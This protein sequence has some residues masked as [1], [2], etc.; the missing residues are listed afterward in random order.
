MFTAQEIELGKEPT[1]PFLGLDERWHRPFLA[2]E[3]VRWAGEI[4][5]VVLAP[6]PGR[7]VDA[8]ELVEVDYEPLPVV[9]DAREALENEVLLFEDAGTNVCLERPATTSDEELFGDCEVTASGTITS[10][11]IAACPIEPRAAAARVEDDDR[12]TVWLSTQTPH[13]DRDGLAAILGTDPGLI[14]VLAPDVGGGFGGKGLE[15]GVRAGRLPG[16]EDGKP[17]R[18]TETR[19]ENLLRCRT[20]AR[21]GSSSR[22]GAAATGPSRRCG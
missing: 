8:A 4:V 18:W 11:R 19:T 1:L 13:Q 15:R 10:Q 6:S 17:V 7:S 2:G 20:G 12:L 21:S 5:A 22:S 3:K 9:T 14:R 16:P